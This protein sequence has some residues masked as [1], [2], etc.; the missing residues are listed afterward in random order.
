MSVSLNIPVK[1][2]VI[3]TFNARGY[4]LY[5]SRMIDTFLRT[6]PSNIRLRVY[7]ENCEVM[8]RAPNLE[9]LDLHGVSPGLC[10]FKQRWG[11]VAKANGD[12]SNEPRLNQRKD[13][14]K[15]FKWDAIR[16]SHKVYAI[17]HASGSVDSEWLIWMDADMV[18]HSPVPISFLDYMCPENQDLC[19]LGRPGKFSEC[20]LYALHLNTKGTVRFLREFERMYNEAE[21]GIFT[22]G[23]WHDSFVFDDVK[24]RIPGLRM[25]NWSSNLGDL[26]ASPT[27]SP[28]EGHPLINSEWG[29]YLDHLKGDNRK[30]AGHSLAKDIKVQ[31]NESYWQ[32]IT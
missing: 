26:R 27:N 5:A 6:W 29:A 23:E 1:Y 32:Q 4:N 11:D 25:L 16:F 9:I 17:F 20:G 2:T 12:I 3:T 22:L 18:C 8:Q 21:N 13:V 19:Y 10:N 14:H 30:Q 15:H 31:R 7:A 24:N 28:G